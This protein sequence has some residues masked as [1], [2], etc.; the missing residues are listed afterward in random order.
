MTAE[1]EP[2]NSYL[3][4][5]VSRGASFLEAGDAVGARLLLETYLDRHPADADARNFAAL[6]CRRLGDLPAAAAHLEQAV[7]AK[8]ADP[9]FAV[10]LAQTLGDMGRAAEALPVLDA[11]LSRVP[12]QADALIQRTTTLTR[13][14]RGAEA[15]ATARMAVAFHRHLGRAH[16]ALGATL[17]RQNLPAEAVK[18]FDDAT[19]LE[20]TAVDSWINRGVALRDLDRLAEAEASYRRALALAPGD[21]I[22]VNNLANV[23]SSQ[24]RSG[25]A[26]ELYRRAVELDPGYAD[27]KAN[28]GMALRDAG[29]ADSEA[30]AIALLEAAVRDHPGNVHLL[31]AYGNTLRQTGRIDDAIAVLLAALGISPGHA[32]VH[33]NLGLAYA[34]QAKMSEAADHMRRAA[35]LKPSS[36]VINNNYGALALR[37]FDFDTAVAAL[38]RAVAEKPDYDEALINLGVAHYMRGDGEDAISAYRRVIAR[39]PDNGFARYSL[40][41]AFLEDQRLAEAEVEIR[42]ALELDPKNAMAHN[43]LGVLLLDQHSIGPARVAMREA[44]DVGTLSAPVFY[45]NYAFA[46]LYAPDV[47]NEEIFAIHKE[48]GRRYATTTPATAKPHRNIR[49]PDRR[50]RVAYLSP[51]FRAHSVAYFFEALL[52]KH[53]RSR[54]E[55]A[56]YSDTART[57]AVTRSMRAAA[58]LWVE[59]GGLSDTAFAQKLV[60][61]RIDILVNLGGHTSGNRLPVC[62]VKPA[63]VQIEYLGYPETSGV[64]AMDYRITDGRADP[65]GIADPWSTETLVRLP[66]CFHCYRPAGTPPDPAPAPHLAKGYITFASFNVL[67]KVTDHAIKAW[68][69]ILKAIPSAR[70]LIKCKQLRDTKVQQLIRDDFAR[71]G[72]DPAR[73]EM[74]SFV[75]SMRDHLDYYAKVDL[76]LD[77]FPYNGTTTTCESLYMGV[78]VLTI[79]G[80]NHRGRVGVSLLTAVGLNRDFIADDVDDYVA[81]AIAFGREPARLAALRPQIR[82][83]LDHSPLR[84]EVGFTR[85]LEAA[86]R[87]LWKRWCAGP[88]TTMFTA[89]PKL[90]PED[91]IQGVLVKTL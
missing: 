7:A 39:N 50:L 64:P 71:H 89:P 4:P 16:N 43:T 70:F 67:P 90:R 24:G 85:A 37:M 29:G 53:D 84:D 19:R 58:D 83:M 68:S 21:A 5:L 1:A 40:G 69:E 77:T 78:P 60:D 13:L 12:G 72:I 88:E 79:A 14:G 86:Y 9:L 18:A 51:D 75:A 15:V 63:P 31:N 36:P 57:D 56:L 33:N 26:V 46:S 47:S 11:L 81:R 52:E 25:E 23:V 38:S 66:D 65:V 76:A 3:S 45:S 35:E 54:F 74:A 8:P 17:L 32:E 20:P 87:D 41:V 73:I 49:D 22:A 6:A 62:A 61:D 30:E 91:S 42:R 48:Y 80:T 28:L 34:L 59:T 10:N 55:I 2:P 82:P 44:A 27:A